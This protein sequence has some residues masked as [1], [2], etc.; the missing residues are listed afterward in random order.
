[1]KKNIFVY[2]I[3]LMLVGSTDLSAKE[4][5][6]W[7]VNDWP[8]AMIVSG[9]YKGKGQHDLLRTIFKKEMPQYEHEEVRMNWARFW[10]MAKNGESICNS[11]AV[12]T[13]ERERYAYFSKALVFALPQRIVL[14]KETK[15][16]LGNPEEYSLKALMKDKGMVGYLE[17]SR[18]YGKSLDFLLK[19]NEAGSNLT[20]N[21]LTTDNFFRM[22]VKGRG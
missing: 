6:T 18:S 11:A 16:L 4:V 21:S 12:K 5:M 2:A 14:R 17:K 15:V 3:F 1:M 9:E 13:I 7:S 8:P 22:M 20:R 10:V 19:K